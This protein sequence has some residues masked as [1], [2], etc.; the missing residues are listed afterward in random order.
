MSTSLRAKLRAK[1]PAMNSETSPSRCRLRC[2]ARAEGASSDGQHVCERLDAQALGG[3]FVEC[4]GA[5]EHREQIDDV[6]FR[7][8]VDVEALTFARGVKCVTKK[9]AQRSDG[10][11]RSR[12]HGLH[13][14]H[15]L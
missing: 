4:L 1:N 15:P 2:R 13:A 12:R 9:F 11:Q 7:L 6:G 8:F 14:W 5:R 10:Y 3:L